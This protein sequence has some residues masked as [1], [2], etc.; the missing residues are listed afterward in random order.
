[1]VV[2]AAQQSTRSRPAG[3]NEQ[4]GLALVMVIIQVSDH[5]QIRCYYSATSNVE[6]NGSTSRREERREF[7]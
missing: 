6:L 1:M 2:D 4:I 3:Q 7:S 5:S